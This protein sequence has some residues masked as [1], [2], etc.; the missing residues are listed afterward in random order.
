MAVF[1]RFDQGFGDEC[2]YTY[3]THHSTCIDGGRAE[4]LFKPGLITRTAVETG[5]IYPSTGL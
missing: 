5:N 1:L 3:I 2:D 4:V